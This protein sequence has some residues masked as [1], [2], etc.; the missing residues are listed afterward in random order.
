MSG[1]LSAFR[2]KRKRSHLRTRCCAG[3]DQDAT[4]SGPVHPSRFVPFVSPFQGFK[5]PGAAQAIA[6][7][8]PRADMCLPPAGQLVR[9]GP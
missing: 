8:L 7:F 4:R 3:S 5:F 2:E 6:T 9:T 1:H